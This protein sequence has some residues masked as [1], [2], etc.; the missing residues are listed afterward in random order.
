VRDPALVRR[1]AAAHPERIAVAIDVREGHVAV[2]GWTETSPIPAVELARRFADCGVA[3]ILHTDIGR[4]GALAGVDA[5]AVAQFARQI[6]IPVI[7]SG[8]VAAL[9]DIA[10]LKAHEADGVAGVVLGRA[11][12]M[13]RIDPR[14]ALALA[15][16]T[17]RAEAPAQEPSC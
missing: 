5:A 13:G 6:P 12:Y 1:A 3:A 4:D 17:S 14:E 10:A 2:R 16:S 15:A 11:L 8:G 9:A 7:A